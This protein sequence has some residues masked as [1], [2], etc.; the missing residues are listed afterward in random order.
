M[1]KQKRVRTGRL[2]F[3]PGLLEGSWDILRDID[4]LLFTRISCQLD[5]LGCTL[6]YL[7]H[8]QKPFAR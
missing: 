2:L 4:G 6:L 1:E 3:G 8:V 5:A 7:G